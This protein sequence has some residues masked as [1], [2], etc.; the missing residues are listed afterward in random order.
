MSRC[1]TPIFRVSYPNVFKAKK[2]D[3]NGNDEYSL[4][5]LFKK[6]ED[7]TVLKKSVQDA[8]IKKW[9][10]D[11][12]K[13]PKA[14]KTPFRD[15]A[16]RIKIDTATGKEIIPAG[17]EKGAIFLTLKNKERP[18]LID[19]KCNDILD[20]ADFYAGCY[21]RATV[22]A[23]AYDQKGNKGVAFGLRN[24]QKV[25]EGEPLTGRTKAQDDFA[26][27]EGVDAGGTEGSSVDDLF[28]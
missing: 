2:N 27:I 1:T 11:K 25:K 26:P 8:V 4:V 24:I 21:A 7:L 20:T 18:G 3:L 23:Y 5:A 6:G 22:E 10:P 13:W 19:A 17:H 15:Q 28:S 16:D 9:G 14:L 12:E